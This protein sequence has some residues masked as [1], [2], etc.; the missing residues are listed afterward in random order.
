MKI[1]TMDRVLIDEA[2]VVS[3][4]CSTSSSVSV[5]V[6]QSGPRG[7]SDWASTFD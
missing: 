6:A 1:L 7:E 5:A 2:G 3:S 4:R